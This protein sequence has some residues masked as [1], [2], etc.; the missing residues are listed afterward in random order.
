MKVNSGSPPRMRGKL[1]QT[2]LTGHFP[3]ITP[4]DAGKTRTMSLRTARQRDHPRGCGENVCICL[5]RKRILGSPPRMRGKRYVSAPGGG[6]RR[7]TPADAGKTSYSGGLPSQDGDHPRGCGENRAGININSCSEGSP[8]R[9]RGKRL[10]KRGD[11]DER[12]ITPADA[13]KTSCICSLRFSLK[14]HPRGCGENCIK[15]S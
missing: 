4:A 3:G 11:A 2:A 10:K 5:Q 9:M 7:I 13:G 15:D 8:P 14:D 12:R 6:F 1:T